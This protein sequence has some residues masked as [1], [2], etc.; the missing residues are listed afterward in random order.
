VV[1]NTNDSGPGSLRQ[2]I[3]DA[4]ANAGADMIAFNISGA[5]AHTIIPA[6]ALPTITDPVTIDGTT[7]PGFSGNPLIE[8]NGSNAFGNGFT[9]NAGSSTVR[10]LIINRFKRST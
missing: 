7:Q 3:L 10:G 4:N 6:S 9:I 2:A 1:T 8:L 5:G